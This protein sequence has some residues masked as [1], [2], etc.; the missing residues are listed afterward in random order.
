LVLLLL[1]NR[2]VLS[3]YVGATRTVLETMKKSMLKSYGHVVRK[4]NNR[5][6]KRILTLVGRRRRGRPDIRREKEVKRV[7][8]QKKLTSEDAVH[9]Q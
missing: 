4:E 3:K 2:P 8:K 6:L 5:W 1:Y 7:M 9:R